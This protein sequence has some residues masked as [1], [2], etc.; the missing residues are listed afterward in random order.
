MK[1]AK[2]VVK[3][4]INLKPQPCEN[5]NNLHINF[6]NYYNYWFSLFI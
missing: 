6:C 5:K 1:K 4:I 3:L 2:F